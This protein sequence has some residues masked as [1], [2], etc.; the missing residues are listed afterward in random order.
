VAGKEG[1]VEQ[2]GF[3]ATRLRT[4][5][6]SVLNIPNAV[7]ASVPIDNMGAPAADGMRDQ[8]SS[9]AA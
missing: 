8:H 2:V 7:I 1:V 9:K 6:G 4:A 5:E 3:R